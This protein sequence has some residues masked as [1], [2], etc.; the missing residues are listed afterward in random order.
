MDGIV[1]EETTGAWTGAWSG[2]GSLMSMTRRA[3]G[4]DELALANRLLS[5][6]MLTVCFSNLY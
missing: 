6:D 4:L 5:D 2:P 3:L 1:D